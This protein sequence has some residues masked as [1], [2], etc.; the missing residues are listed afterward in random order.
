[1]PVCGLFEECPG[2][3]VLSP[4]PRILA[5]LPALFTALN[6]PWPWGTPPWSPESGRSPAAVGIIPAGIT[7]MSCDCPR[8]SQA[9]EAGQ[10]QA[11]GMVTFSSPGSTAREQAAAWAEPAAPTWGRSPRCCLSHE[12]SSTPVWKHPAPHGADPRETEAQL[13]PVGWTLQ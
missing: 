3:G 5:P 2:L 11:T 1:M 10:V 4:R 8:G 12:V 6:R 13:M 7:R 9:E